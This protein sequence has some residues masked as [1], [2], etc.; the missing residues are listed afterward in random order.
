M[1]DFKIFVF[2]AIREF[3]TLICYPD[4]DSLVLLSLLKLLKQILS[5]PP[6]GHRKAREVFHHTH[7]DFNMCCSKLENRQLNISEVKDICKKKLLFDLL[8]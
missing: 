2:S 8:L 5:V 3:K 7:I 6:V 1:K 4:R